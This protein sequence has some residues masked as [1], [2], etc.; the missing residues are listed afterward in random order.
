MRVGRRRV[1]KSFESRSPQQARAP[2][3]LVVRNW[4]GPKH[5]P[6][7][8]Q[9][10]RTFKGFSNTGTLTVWSFVGRFVSPKQV[11]AVLHLNA[12]CDGKGGTLNL[13]LK[14]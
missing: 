3:D 6:V 11:R 8:D 13:A 7:C 12:I 14:A 5:D 2:R 9:G 10:R 4:Q 1:R